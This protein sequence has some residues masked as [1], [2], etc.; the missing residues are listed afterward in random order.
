MENSKQHSAVS[1]VEKNPVYL[2][3]GGNS[4]RKKTE[5]LIRFTLHRMTKK[6]NPRI[7]Y[8][9]T[10]SKDNQV[11]LKNMS[12]FFR[13]TASATTQLVP[14]SQKNDSTQRAKEILSD[15][16]IIF[17]GGGDVEAGI[18][19]L[20]ERRLD[21]FL[22]KLHKQGMPFL[23]ISAGSIMLCKEW[24]HWNNRS[25]GKTV[26]L[27]P[28]LG[29][30]DILC[31]THDENADWEELKSA[32]MLEKNGKCGYG[33]PA[34]AAICAEKNKIVAFGRNVFCFQRHGESIKRLP[35]IPA[36]IISTL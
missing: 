22:R 18:Q 1:I 20:N 17:L 2:L 26:H 30:V 6:N 27:F 21:V 23:G 8:I 25:L 13:K 14:L 3:A 4:S 31:D 15:T 11:F 34:D 12:E 33:I 32:L 36:Q 24:V 19:V 35:D 7:A 10:A 28:C 16:D 29:I 5:S 9:G